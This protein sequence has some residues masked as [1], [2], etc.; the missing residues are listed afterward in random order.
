MSGRLR[1]SRNSILFFS[2]PSFLVTGVE[3]LGRLKLLELCDLQT[4][5]MNILSDCKALCFFWVQ[6]EGIA[7][8]CKALYLHMFDRIDLLNNKVQEISLY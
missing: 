4:S 2:C 6:K 8:D 5:L 3:I 7:Q 1:N